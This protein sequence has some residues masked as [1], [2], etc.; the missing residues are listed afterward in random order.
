MSLFR[1]R[2]VNLSSKLLQSGTG[3]RL[4][5]WVIIHIPALIP[6]KTLFETTSLSVYFHP[7]PSYPFHVIMVPKTNIPDVQSLDISKNSD[8]IQDVF[9]STQKIVKEYQLE[10][11][12]YRLIVNGGKNQDFPIIHFHLISDQTNPGKKSDT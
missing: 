6:M 5:V 4:V 8:F 3:K 11:V 10:K 12:G 2:I 1:T 9:S 7:Q